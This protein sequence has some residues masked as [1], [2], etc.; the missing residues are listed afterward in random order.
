MKK[1]ILSLIL[2]ISLVFTV[3]PMQIFATSTSHTTSEQGLSLIKGFE[4]FSPVAVVDGMQSAIGYGI[5]CDPQDYPNGITEVEADKL[6]REEIIAFETTV[7]KFTKT[8]NVVLTQNQFDALVSVTFNLGPAW[9]NSSYRFW[10]MLKDGLENYTDNE[11][12]SAIGVWSHIG[13]NLSTG[14]L[15]RRVAEIQLF[16]HGD[17]T[18]TSSPSFHYLI[19]NGN[20]GSIGTDVM[21]YQENKP[22][23]EFTSAKM[24]GKYFTGWYDNANGQGQPLG[25]N[26]LAKSSQTVYAGWSSTKPVVPEVPE[27]PVV[28]EVPVDPEVPVVPPRVPSAQFS[29]VYI[30]DWFFPYV[31][32]LTNATIISGYSDK[33]F[34]PMNQVTN[35]EALKL[36]LTAADFRDVA[37]TTEH[38]ASGYHDL[39]VEKGF[40]SATQVLD[41]EE[42]IDRLAAVHLTAKTLGIAPS[43]KKSVFSDVDDAY[44]TAL[45]EKGIVA[46]EPG[47]NGDLLFYPNREIARCEIT[48][49]TW[50]ILQQ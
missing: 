31:I 48:K 24:Q 10:S 15:K 42:P 18:G 14:L 39:A 29:D 9:V 20:G 5:M 40:I 33:T 44:A 3:M 8:H 49:I 13:P 17:Y 30:D 45:F 46:G 38:W 41:L 1:R 4:G 12:A 21:L 19:F 50:M 26:D 34:R 36:I 25:I 23:V 27:I 7:N 28:P 35:G 37:P 47:T 43:E 6:L 11:I 32:E 16:I 2:L 22:Y